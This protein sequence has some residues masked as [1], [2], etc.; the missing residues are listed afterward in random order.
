M[1]IT[2]FKSLVN[3]F[4]AKRKNGRFDSLKQRLSSGDLTVSILDDGSIHIKEAGQ[5]AYKPATQ[6]ELLAM[7]LAVVPSD[8]PLFRKNWRELTETGA[9]LPVAK[10]ATT[11]IE[12]PKIET[13]DFA[14]A[15]KK[16]HVALTVPVAEFTGDMVQYVGKEDKE[17]LDAALKREVAAFEQKKFVLTLFSI[18][19]TSI[20]IK[21]VSD[22]ETTWTVKLRSGDE[23]LFKSQ[24]SKT[25]GW[26]LS[27]A[28]MVEIGDDYYY[29]AVLHQPKATPAV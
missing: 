12:E 14:A 5:D 27:D 25:E 13:L 1:N 15:L 6:E 2:T 22:T 23:R 26:A 10:S 4:A 29:V 19:A 3:V 16:D 7:L 9:V 28:A 18:P 8:L 11:E 17:L 21:E 24:V 20:S